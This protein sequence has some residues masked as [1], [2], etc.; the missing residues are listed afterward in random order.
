VTHCAEL[1]EEINTFSTKRSKKEWELKQ[2]T[3]SPYIFVGRNFQMPKSYTNEEILVR[4]HWRWQHHGPE[5]SLLK[6]IYIDP[7]LKSYHG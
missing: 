5:C 7:Y 2:Y 3:K 6:H 4:G 1:K